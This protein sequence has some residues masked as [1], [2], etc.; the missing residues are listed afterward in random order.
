[1]A[2]PSA[3]ATGDE[4]TE[5]PSVFHMDP[6][7]QA[8]NWPETDLMPD[9]TGRVGSADCDERAGAGGGAAA[10]PDGRP[11]A[12]G[13]ARRD[14]QGWWKTEQIRETRA[15]RDWWQENTARHDSTWTGKCLVRVFKK[16]QHW[17]IGDNAT[18]AAAT[19]ATHAPPADGHVPVEE[20]VAEPPTA[21]ATQT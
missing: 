3:C 21:A 7:E 13:G 11:T 5:S 19:G 12:L 1:M 6:P 8:A 4:G 9:H 18:T 16:E 2:R 14:W 15:D 20:R 17:W 10:A